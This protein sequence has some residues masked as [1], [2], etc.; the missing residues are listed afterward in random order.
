[1]NQTQPYRQSKESR[2]NSTTMMNEFDWSEV[3]QDLLDAMKEKLEEVPDLIRFACVCPL[4]RSV[5]SPDAVL[6]HKGRLPWPRKDESWNSIQGDY[7]YSDI[8]FY[9]GN[10]Y[11]LRCTGEVDVVNGLHNYDV[12]ST[13]PAAS[14]VGSVGQ[15][16]WGDSD[17]NYL[18]VSN[19]DLLKLNFSESKWLEVEGVGDLALFLGSN[20]S[21]SVVVSDF[22]GYRGNS[23]YFSDDNFSKEYGHDKGIFNLK[24]GS[25]EKIFPID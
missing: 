24:D 7:H 11:A 3:H 13:A 21:F 4:W 2:N 19:N 20:D 5:V 17:R 9:K 23:I 16:E 1:M 10:L 8:T 18:V 25:I 12:S 22:P 15:N 6:G 14:L